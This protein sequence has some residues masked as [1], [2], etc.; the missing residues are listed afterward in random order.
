[1]ILYASSEMYSYIIT[2]K[3]IL[4]L[5]DNSLTSHWQVMGGVESRVPLPITESSR[6]VYKETIRVLGSKR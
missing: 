5:S 1:M 4:N 6:V 3:I 2:Y